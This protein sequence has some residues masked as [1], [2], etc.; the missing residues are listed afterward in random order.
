M[1]WELVDV[2]ARLLPI[3]FGRS[4]ESEES[5]ED[6]KKVNVTLIFKED[7]GNP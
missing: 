3:I 1:L 5:L 4:W 7:L 2:A 6:W